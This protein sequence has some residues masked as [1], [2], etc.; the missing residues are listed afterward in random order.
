MKTATAE[1]LKSAEMDLENV[2]Q[3]I[4]LEHLTPIA[5]E[6]AGDGLR[7]TNISFLRR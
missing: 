4:H 7:M 2:G 1:W 3:I 5:A 6:V